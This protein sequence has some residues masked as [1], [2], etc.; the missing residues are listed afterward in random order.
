MWKYYEH[1]TFQYFIL[2][3]N[4]YN[5]LPQYLFIFLLFK[6]D[7]KINLIFPHPMHVTKPD[8]TSKLENV[9]VSPLLPRKKHLLPPKSKPK[10]QI[11]PSSPP[12]PPQISATTDRRH[13]G[14]AAYSVVLYILVWFELKLLVDFAIWILDEK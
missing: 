10:T 11:L 5:F 9:K 13:H 1:I 6:F 8:T 12:P 4:S 2:L 7:L 14:K 3:K